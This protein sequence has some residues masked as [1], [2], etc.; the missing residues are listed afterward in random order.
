[1]ILDEC[2][3]VRIAGSQKYI[4]CAQVADDALCVVGATATPVYNY[5]DEVFNIFDIIKK[6][7]LGSREEFLR[8]WG[9]RLGNHWGVKDP[10]ALREYLINQNLMLQRTRKDVGRELPEAIPEIETVESDEAKFTEMMA[11]HGATAEILAK[12][13][14]S[15]EELFT[16]SGQFEWQLREATGAAKAPFVAA[17]VR[18]ILTSEKK[19]VMFGWHHKVYDIW[20]EELAEFN[21]VFYGG[22]QTP[23]KKAESKGAFLND[24]EC[25]VMVI[26]LRSG[27][28]LDGLQEVCR[29]AVFG[30]LDWSP[31]MH[32]QCIGRLRRDGMTDP[33]IAYFLVS[34]HGSDPFVAEKL[35]LK[36]GQSIPFMDPEAELLELNDEDAMS[37]RSFRMA[38]EFLARH[39]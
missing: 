25:R 24:P 2:Q 16:L 17:A 31:T 9:R 15:R 8:E 6:G 13:E 3:E 27:A 5:G 33:V 32:Q 38:E 20:R 1:V 26:S 34:E 11:A 23:A 28:G 19:V 4:G 21:P 7:C 29:V 22:Q 14:A 10:V 37:G 36:R 35:Q 30:E 39:G 12:R 18:G